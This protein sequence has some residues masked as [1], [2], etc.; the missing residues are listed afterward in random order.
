MIIKWNKQN[1]LVLRDWD[2]KR[3]DMSNISQY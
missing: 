2:R 1:I 3:R